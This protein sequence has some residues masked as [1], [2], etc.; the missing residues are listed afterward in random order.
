MLE[1]KCDVKDKNIM[2]Q[3][4]KKIMML[5]CASAVG[6]IGIWYVGGPNV[7]GFW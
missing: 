6:G 1:Q 5:L 7:L 2:F 3:F 4:Q